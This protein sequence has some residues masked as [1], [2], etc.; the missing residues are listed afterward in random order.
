MLRA[1]EAIRVRVTAREGTSEGRNPRDAFWAPLRGTEQFSN[2]R[3]T[4]LEAKL[5][6]E[7]GGELRSRLLEQL[8]E[9]FRVLDS[10][11][12]PGG[13]REFEKMFFHYM[14]PFSEKEAYRYQFAEAFTRYLEHRQQLFRENMAFRA[15]QERL[16]AA[17][18]IFFST[19]ISGY[20]SLSFDLSTGSFGQ[21]AR[22][23]DSNFDTFRVFLDAFIPVAFAEV[24]NEDFS[25]RFDFTVSIP[26]S[27]E[28]AFTSAARDLA[29]AQTT[30]SPKSSGQA[31]GPAAPSAAR[32]RAEYIWLLA[33]GSLL[34]PV[35][36]A[37]AVM[38]YGIRL[39]S[40]IRSS[41]FIALQPILQHQLELLKE[42]RLR[43][44][45]SATPDSSK[46]GGVP[47]QAQA[48]G[49]NR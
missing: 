48:T 25:N 45:V 9:G 12:F 46:A 47:S 21:L 24:F 1:A 31:V 41:E 3:V 23:F 14:E 22:A 19:R 2:L 34:V 49:E 43:I 11:L 10:D 28:Q 44:T 4:Q 33:N 36:I 5:C 20:A 18:D 27:V 30:G 8:S 7:F 6:R 32:A 16:A 42:D 35:L 37:L 39:L 29:V 40:E 38:L 15:A 13:L 17:A 26:S